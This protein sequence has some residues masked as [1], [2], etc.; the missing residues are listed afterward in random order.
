METEDN[1]NDLKDTIQRRHNS[2]KKTRFRGA[3]APADKIDSIRPALMSTDSSTAFITAVRAIDPD[4]AHACPA[5]T[6]PPPTRLGI[7]TAL[8][9]IKNN[10]GHQVGSNKPPADRRNMQ[11]IVNNTSTTAEQPDIAR[12]DRQNGRRAKNDKPGIFVFP[13]F[14]LHPFA[15][16]F[17]Y[18]HQ[19]QYFSQ[20]SCTL[21]HPGQVSRKTIRHCGQTS[22]PDSTCPEQPGHLPDKGISGGTGL[23]SSIQMK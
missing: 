5:A 22:Q 23:S 2:R 11:V 19:G 20:L 16:S 21:P 18:L 12:D 7:I 1:T 17:I 6:A 4:V 14:Y 9:K 13:E 3:D 8:N 10:A 15:A